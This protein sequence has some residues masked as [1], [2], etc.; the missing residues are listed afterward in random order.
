VEVMD[1]IALDF[2]PYILS[3]FHSGRKR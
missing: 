3:V 1:F 2:V